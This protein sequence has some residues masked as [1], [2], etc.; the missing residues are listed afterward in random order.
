MRDLSFWILQRPCCRFCAKYGHPHRS[1]RG[2]APVALC[3]E[4]GAK[5]IGCGSPTPGKPIETDVCQHLIK[6]Y[7]FF[8]QCIAGI[9]P[10]LEFLSDPGELP[11]RRIVEKITH[12]GWT[13]PLNF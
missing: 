5:K 13:R 8:G 1:Q 2:P 10:K 7:T 6:I 4:I 12:R 9:R 3:V 11:H